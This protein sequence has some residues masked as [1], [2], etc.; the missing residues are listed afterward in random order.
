MTR[1]MANVPPSSSKTMDT[2]V[3]VGSPRV[4]NTSRRMTSDIITARKMKNTSRKENIDGW[5]TP[6]LATSIIP[7]LIEAPMKTPTAATIMMVLKVAT[8]APIAE[9]RKL[10]ASLLT[11]EIRSKTA[12]TKRKAVNPRYMLS[13]EILFFRGK[14]P[15]MMLG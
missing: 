2:V 12:R 13:I 7:L 10:T 15:G 8:F 9:L 3:D 5:N 6:C 1:A 4:L 14:Y 11:P